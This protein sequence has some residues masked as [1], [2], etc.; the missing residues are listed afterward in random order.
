[1]LP[2]FRRE[3]PIARSR[4]ELGEPVERPDAQI[5]TERIEKGRELLER[6]LALHGRGPSV[7]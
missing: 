3:D 7:L 2:Q 5:D 1:V 4:L 6:A